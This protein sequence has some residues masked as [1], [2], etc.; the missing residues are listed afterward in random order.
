MAFTIGSGGFSSLF[1]GFPR[2]VGNDWKLA[3]R[4]AALIHE[5]PPAARGLLTRSADP[6]RELAGRTA[7]PVPPVVLAGERKARAQIEHVEGCE[8][9]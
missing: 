9:G 5:P 4:V 2:S 8:L 7:V 6:R 3:K 1:R